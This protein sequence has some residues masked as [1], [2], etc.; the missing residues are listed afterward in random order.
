[1]GEYLA[2]GPLLII[3]MMRIITVIACA[4]E[5]PQAKVIGNYLPWRPTLV[6]Q[7]SDKQDYYRI[8]N[9]YPTIRQKHKWMNKDVI[10]RSYMLST[11]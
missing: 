5:C 11:I 2:I 6:T 10:T 3:A 7:I 8:S 1:M 9:T 4:L